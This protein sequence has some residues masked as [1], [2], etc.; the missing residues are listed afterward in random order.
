MGCRASVPSSPLV[1]GNH[2]QE[3]LRGELV[4]GAALSAHRP[5]PAADQSPATCGA[6]ASCWPSASLS[7]ASP[8]RPADLVQPESEQ[9]ARFAAIRGRGH[10]PRG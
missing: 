6:P 3:E 10:A 2:D 4:A 7:S 1:P 8:E 9:A 5:A